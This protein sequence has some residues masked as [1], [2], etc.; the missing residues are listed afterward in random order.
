MGKEGNMF[1]ADTVVVSVFSQNGKN[2]KSSFTFLILINITEIIPQLSEYKWHWQKAHPELG[3]WCGHLMT[4]HTCEGTKATNSLLAALPAKLLAVKEWETGPPPAASSWAALSR[5]CV[6][7]S[8]QALSHRV[9][10]S[11]SAL[12]KAIT[13]ICLCSESSKDRNP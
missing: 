9:W 12:N 13:L 11:S 2:M 6:Q 3:G 4:H 1:T 5:M 7:C 10:A 8:L